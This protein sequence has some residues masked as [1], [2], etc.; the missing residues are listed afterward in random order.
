MD[1]PATRHKVLPIRLYDNS[2]CLCEWPVEV[3][4][5]LLAGQVGKDMAEVQ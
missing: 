3:G 5:Q 1:L 4:I 2:V